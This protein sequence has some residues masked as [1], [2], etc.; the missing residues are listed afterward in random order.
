MIR[1]TKFEVDNDR[2]EEVDISIDPEWKQLCISLLNK[3][4]KRSLPRL[5]VCVVWSRPLNN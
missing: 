2:G 4:T 3:T 1:P 5:T